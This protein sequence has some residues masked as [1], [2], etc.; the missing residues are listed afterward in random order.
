[1][2]VVEVERDFASHSPGDVHRRLAD[3]FCQ[4][5]PRHHLARQQCADLFGYPFAEQVLNS[6]P[7]CH[8]HS[9]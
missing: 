5:G 1:L 2:H 8:A 3:G 7:V 9:L 4:L 6:D